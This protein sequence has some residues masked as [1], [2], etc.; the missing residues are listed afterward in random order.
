ML[1]LHYGIGVGGEVNGQTQ[2]GHDGNERRSADL[3]GA[4]DGPGILDVGD[5][6]VGRL[7]GEEELV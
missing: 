7:V 3:H 5:G 6:D 4:N 1:D 2:H